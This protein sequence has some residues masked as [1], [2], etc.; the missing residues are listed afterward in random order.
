[1]ILVTMLVFCGYG[2]AGDSMGK[3]EVNKNKAIKIARFVEK[4]EVNEK[5]GNGWLSGSE[6]IDAAEIKVISRAQ[7]WMNINSAKYKILSHSVTASYIGSPRGAWGFTTVTIL[8]E[9]R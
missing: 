5:Y 7:T 3:V 8:Y 4:P 1:M 2:F 6:E 9:E